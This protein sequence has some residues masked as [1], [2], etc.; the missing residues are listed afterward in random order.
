MAWFSPQPLLVPDIIALNAGFLS[1]KPAVEF[2]G[3][4]RSWTEFGAGTARIA[5]ALLGTGLEK[6]DRVVVLMSNTYETAE[7][8]FGIIR[9]GL[10]AVPLNCSIT[11]DAVAGMID[12]SNARAVIACG[13]HMARIDGLRAR[14]S[15]DVQTRLV[16]VKPVTD[17]WLDYPPSPLRL[18][19]NATSSTALARPACRKASC[20]ITR[21]ARRGG[22]TWPSRCATTP[23]RAR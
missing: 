2:E 21:A 10:C 5:N 11:D 19:T 9:A 14:L 20:T 23:G 17:G 4:V 12:N 3:S 8:M 16:G 1:A 18:P 6:G 13:E 22:R 7:A 15:D